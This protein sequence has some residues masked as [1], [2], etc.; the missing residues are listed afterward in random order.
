MV[1][2]TPPEPI[3]S[4]VRAMH[5]E[6]VAQL[7]LTTNIHHPAESGRAREE[8]VRMFLRRFVPKGLGVD[9]GFVID[10]AGGMSRQIDIVI[11]RDNYHPVLEI[12]GLKHF[13]IE[14][15]VAVIENKA[16]ITSR[17]VLREALDNVRSVKQ[18]DRSGGG[19]NYI[20]M[21]FHGQGPRV[22]IK[23]PHHRVWT[24]IIAEES[25]TP[26][27]FLEEIEA[28]MSGH[29]MSLWLDCFVS[30]HRFAS[31]YVDEKTG[32][33]WYPDKAH[34]LVLSSPEQAGGEKPLVD[35]ALR[36]AG[37]LRHAAIVDYSPPHYFPGSIKHQAT[38]HLPGVDDHPHP[39]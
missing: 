28:D 20:V 32:M 33:V 38:L 36:L 12:G 39:H 21:D 13:F 8:I 34:A 9:T 14:S 6:V 17:G 4:I 19:R 3:A 10:N 16:A 27:T 31:N 24:A 29:D 15:V 1:L 22:D 25:L 35:F 37:H 30:I 7:A 26:D 18:L 23:E 2:P 11:Y 5:D